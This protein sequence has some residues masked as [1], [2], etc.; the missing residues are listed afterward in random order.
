MGADRQDILSAAADLDAIDEE[1]RSDTL[2][3]GPLS[4]YP[5]RQR[6]VPLK[7][8]EGRCRRRIRTLGETYYPDTMSN[9]AYGNQH[10]DSENFNAAL[11][12]M[13]A[14]E[15]PIIP[16]ITWIYDSDLSLTLGARDLMQRSL[17]RRRQVQGEGHPEISQSIGSKAAVVQQTSNNEIST[18]PLSPDRSAPIS[19]EGTYKI[20]T[21]DVQEAR[22]RHLSLYDTEISA[23]LEELASCLFLETISSE[24]FHLST[25]NSVTQMHALK[26]GSG[27]REFRTFVFRGRLKW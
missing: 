20:W 17:N 26:H 22:S 23:G 9:L 24:N 18:N 12:R 19:R 11:M 25:R 1:E 16:K 2:N 10:L 15:C 5:K 6:P 3:S 14:D 27:I 7:V 13:S 4:T 8:Q 21:Q